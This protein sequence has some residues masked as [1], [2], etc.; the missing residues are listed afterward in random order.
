MALEC[1]QGSKP[2]ERCREARWNRE[3]SPSLPRVHQPV[4]SLGPE[5]GHSILVGARG[6]RLAFESLLSN[7]VRWHLR[8][9]DAPALELARLQALVEDRTDPN[10]LSPLLPLEIPDGLMAILGDLLVRQAAHCPLNEAT[11]VGPLLLWFLCRGG[12]QNE[13]VQR[14]S[15]EEHILQQFSGKLGL[16]GQLLQRV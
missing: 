2:A 7:L 3:G 5:V 13:A 12:E 16:L 4:P 9:Y 11:G 8:A 14:L 1:L 6:H 15:D 10:V